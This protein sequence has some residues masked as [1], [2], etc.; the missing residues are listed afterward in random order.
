MQESI[1]IYMSVQSNAMYFIYRKGDVEFQSRAFHL[2][3]CSRTPK[4]HINI[5]DINISS[6]LLEHSVQENFL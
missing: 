5:I 1:D 6:Y 2:E 3:S 4:R